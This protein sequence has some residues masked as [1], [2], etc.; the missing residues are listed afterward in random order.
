MINHLLELR[1]NRYPKK[2]EIKWKV[3]S[4]NLSFA[5]TM[6]DSV[7]NYLG[8]VEWAFEGSSRISTASGL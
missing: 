8:E 4:G 5:A 3:K 6:V 1:V 7:N 2:P